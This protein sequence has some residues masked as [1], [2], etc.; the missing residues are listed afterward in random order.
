M[1]D[2]HSN[3]SSLCILSFLTLLCACG[4]GGG[5]NSSAENT[6]VSWT[7]SLADDDRSL[8]IT[9]VTALLGARVYAVVLSSGILDAGG[10][11][12]Q[13]SAAF[14]KLK[15]TADADSGGPTAL[16]DD[17]VEAPGNPYPDPRVVREDLSIHIPDRFILRGLPDTPALAGARQL[18]RATAAEVEPIKGFSTTAPIRIPLSD[19][20]DLDTVTP[21]TLRFFE[22][23]NQL[24]LVSETLR[25]AQRRGV[26]P[27]E[28]ALAFSFPTQPIEDD[29]LAVRT[30]LQE[31]A[32]NAPPA[33]TLDDPDPTDD[34][35][36][37]VFGP[38]D[39]PF[40]DFLAMNP[41]VAAVARGLITTPDFR[42]GHG[43]FDAEEVAGRKPP[44]DNVIDFVATLPAGAES[45]P[46]V[47]ILQHGFGGSD[48][49]LLDLAGEL[50]AQG[51]ATFAISAVSHGLRGSPLDLV[52]SSP[53]QLRDILR[54][55][56]SDQMTVVSAI[57]SGLDLNRDGNVDLSTTDIGYLGVS[58][59]GILG[60]TFV[61]V[62]NSVPIAVLNVAGGRVAFLGN[63]PGTRP[64]FAASLAMRAG[65]DID[66]PEFEVFLQRMFEV[67]QQALDSADPLNF[68]RHWHIDPFP[69]AEP[70]RI[71]LQEGIGD[72]LVANEST[73]ALAV[74]GGL[75][76]DMVM[77]NP[78]G[79][80]GLW[81]FAPP[82]GHGIISRADV[83]RQALRFLGSHGTEIINP[84]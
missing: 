16:F 48:L 39:A 24:L 20:I 42:D 78:Q 3:R 55:T 63:N 25:E 33:I 81:R 58:L 61:A 30:R 40:A 22:R 60:S 2:G 54:Q 46:P 23:D 52:T 37:G 14:Q 82:G 8:L 45:P 75:E 17:D 76:G 13:A 18:L 43:I 50:G 71:L 21:D 64:I 9:P 73:E 51:F 1:L 65:L 34:L 56:I 7:A 62:E 67:G 19:P 12:L 44:T 35:P 26:A 36:I 70:R 53:V 68:A 74:A 69:G 77:Q 15:G 4:G 66:S 11:S 83:Q 72:L 84:D 5:S 10:R 6:T 80:S 79:V 38:N 41:G 28:V 27:E 49:S 29:L 47:V 57:E 32:R 59:G 31:R